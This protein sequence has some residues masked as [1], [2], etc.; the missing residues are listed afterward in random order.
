MDISSVSDMDW[1]NPFSQMR[2]VED[3]VSKIFGQDDSN[4][5]GVLS[6]DETPLS[7]EMFSSIDSDGDGNITTEELQADMET[8][9]TELMRSFNAEACFFHMFR[10]QGMMGQQ[11]GRE[12]TSQASDMV[13]NI[14]SKD[15]SNEDGVLSI[16]ETPLSEEIFSSIDSD[17]DGNI[18]ME[19]LQA[20]LESHMEEMFSH[21]GGPG[22]M[23]HSPPPPKNEGSSETEDETEDSETSE[24]IEE[25]VA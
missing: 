15:D 19:E 12:Q 21:I 5:D 2:N 24:A 14:F 25:A 6:I 1:S 16:D 17:G 9:Q 11:A 18:T 10:M 20:D 22:M 13:S 4:E 3:E 7:E 8:K 23:P